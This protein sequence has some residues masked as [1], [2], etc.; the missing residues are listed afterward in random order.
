MLIFIVFQSCFEESTYF[1]QTEQTQI[2]EDYDNAY[3]LP[4]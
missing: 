4:E 1:E 2:Q 3:D